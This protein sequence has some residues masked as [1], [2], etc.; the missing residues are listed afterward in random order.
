MLNLIWNER[1]AHLQ[2]VH[3]LFILLFFLD[4]NETRWKLNKRLVFVN[5]YKENSFEKSSIVC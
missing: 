4:V 3:C 1:F 5:D 2:S